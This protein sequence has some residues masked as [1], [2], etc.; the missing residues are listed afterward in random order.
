MVAAVAQGD[1][2]PMAQDGILAGKVAVVTGGNKGIGRSI[3][4]RLAAD[5]AQ[6]MIGA[7]DAAGN[8]A[9]VAAIAAAGGTAGALAVDLRDPQGPGRLIQAGA[10]RFGGLDILVNNAGDTR[11]GAFEKLTDE[12][13]EAGFS[14]KYYSAMRSS[15]AAWPLLTAS[16]GVIVNIAGIGGRVPAADFA[17]GASVNAA[18]GA[19]TKSLADA[20]IAHGLRVVAINPGTVETDRLQYAAKAWAE[21]DGVSVPEMLTRLATDQK[22]LRIGQPEDISAIVAF[23]V[24][25]AASWITGSLIDVDGGSV[26]GI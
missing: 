25:P 12:D 14:L 21:R 8:D 18:V 16:K 2:S 15:R 13:F 5:G 11:F 4:L 22:A 1:G 7:R 10:D 20:G 6:V 3:A 23:L 9:V 24:S 17:I 26:K 19:L